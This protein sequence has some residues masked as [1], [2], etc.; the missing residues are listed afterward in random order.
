MP[1][2]IA[3]ADLN[4]NLAK[5]YAGGPDGPRSIVTPFFKSTAATPVAPTAMLARYE[6]GSRSSAHYHTVDQFQVIL[7]GT[8]TFGRHH[9]APYCV[10]FSR[11]YTPYGPLQSDKDTGWAFLVMRTRH[12]QGPQRMPGARE[13]LKQM[14]GRQPWQA[15]ARIAFAEQAHGASMVESPDIKDEQGLYTRSVTMAPD[16]RITAPD[17]ADGDGQYVIA[18]KGSLWYGNKEHQALTVVFIKPEEGPFEICSGPSGLQAI[19]LNFPRVR[20]RTAAS[21]VPVGAAE[22]KVLKCVLCDFSYDEKR[23]LPEEGI[24]AGTRWEDI[25]ETWT[26]PD[27][28]ASKSDFQPHQSLPGQG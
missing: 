15:T 22:H 5:P 24:S 17:P 18:V 4:P 8:G 9:V 19:V 7:D 14:P 12:D 1:L 27:C 16:T 6:P 10:H 2:V 21:A 11:A 3:H 20:P 13:K 28:G 26:C 25:P 23:G